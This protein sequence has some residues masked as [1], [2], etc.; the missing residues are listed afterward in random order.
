MM[1]DSIKELLVYLQ[2]KGLTENVYSAFHLLSFFSAI[3]V[4]LWL[5]KKMN[6]GRVRAFFALLATCVA[7]LVL[8]H[9]IGYIEASLGLGNFGRK[10]AVT[11]Y[12]WIPLICFG[13]SKMTKISWGK[14]CT[15]MAPTMPLIEA[16]SRPGC[17]FAGCCKG[18]ECSWGIYNIHT[19]DF[20]FPMPAFEMLWMLGVAV[21]ILYLLKRQEYKPT[22]WL[23]PLMLVVLGGLHF[24]CEFFI[25]NAKMWGSWSLR[26]FHEVSMVVVGAV[27][28][29]GSYLKQ[30]KEKE[31][32]NRFKRP[33]Q[34]AV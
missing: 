13:V 29:W 9:L 2:T 24:A 31:R 12:I 16:V 28:L 18:F 30:T 22:R 23:Y 15:M 17:L 34:K 20:R 6:V 8:I 21:L 32:K 1:Q 33:K 3:P 26:S 19:K 7:F 10:N 25:D 14:L 27:W 4:F 11:I 5:A